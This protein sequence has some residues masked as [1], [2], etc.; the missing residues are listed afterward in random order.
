MAR[1][2]RHVLRNRQAKRPAQQTQ[3]ERQQAVDAE[4]EVVALRVLL[5]E[6]EA[7]IRFSASE[8]LSSLG[9]AVAEAENGARAL[10]LLDA[11]AFDVLFT[12]IGLPDM[13]GDKLA[14]LAI[15]KQPNLCVIF[16]SGYGAPRSD[17]QRAGLGDAV[18]LEK[19][20]SERTMVEAIA[21]ARSRAKV[22]RPE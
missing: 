22:S 3:A 12:D 18:T 6:D 9:H 5:V 4:S 17:L 15:G 19:P 16:A 14:A 20:Y 2:D 21:L 13:P 11:G 7:I 1:E 8:M 10:A